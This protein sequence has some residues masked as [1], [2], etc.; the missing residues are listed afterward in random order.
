METTAQG[1]TAFRGEAESGPVRTIAWGKGQNPVVIKGIT[2]APIF[3]TTIV[4]VI[5]S[6][7]VIIT[8]KTKKSV[9]QFDI[10][11]IVIVT[12]LIVILGVS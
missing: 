1:T 9:V 6:Q 11:I 3:Q 4:V 8:V 10:T 5:S 12:V 7:R 2:K